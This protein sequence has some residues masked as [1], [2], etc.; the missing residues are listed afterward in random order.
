MSEP[1]LT[2]VTVSLAAGSV[3]VGLVGLLLVVSAILIRCPPG[4]TLLVSGG[5]SRRRFRGAHGR[6][7]RVPLIEVA[8]VVDCSPLAVDLPLTLPG[9]GRLHVQGTV[10]LPIIGDDAEKAARLGY[11]LSRA[12]LERLVH[13]LLRGAV[14]AVSRHEEVLRQPDA[15]RTLLDLAQLDRLGLICD[16]LRVVSA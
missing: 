14:Q 12:E 9:G 2:P 3:L 4:R 11:P 10:R 15:A 8:D 7:L 13:A 5:L 6:T 16:D 1:I